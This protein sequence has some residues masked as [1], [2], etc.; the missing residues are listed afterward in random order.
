MKD[1]G[2]G[3][4][5]FEPRRWLIQTEEDRVGERIAFDSTAAPTFPFGGGV[6]GCFR[7]RLAYLE[8]RLLLVL[9]IWNFELQHCPKGGSL[10]IKG[11]ME[12]FT[13]QCIVL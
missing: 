3:L 2:Y 4:D 1:N 10:G 11:M 7:R 9:I 6:R 12:L 8:L 13:N 5:T